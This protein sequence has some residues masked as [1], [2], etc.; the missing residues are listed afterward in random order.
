MKN[1]PRNRQPV[2]KSNAIGQVSRGRLL[3]GVFILLF[4][5]AMILFVSS[6]RWN[7]DMAWVY[8][9]LTTA[10]SVM[11]RILM[12]RK[13][14]DLMAERAN[15]S[16]KSDTK[17]W[18]KALMPLGIIIAIVMLM[19]AGLDKRF[20]W[21]PNLPVII[22]IAAFFILVLG[23][24]WGTWAMVINNFFSS[25]VRIQLD[26]GHT[27]VSSGPYGLMRHPAYA[28]SILTSLATPFLLGSLW[29][30]IPASLAV[31]QLV[32]RTAM[33]D[34]TLQEELEGYPGYAER[35]RYRLF[36]GVW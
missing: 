33:E 36:P 20:E 26:R 32:I 35:V 25:E 29:A 23:F 8:I 31:C 13:N 14:P 10:F 11:S 15:S 2:E 30:L 18:D 12:L 6:G 5:P 34:K 27:V 17:S 3:L 22:R 7:W 24:S 19:A 21:S 16:K 9:G 1:T 4:F 28:G